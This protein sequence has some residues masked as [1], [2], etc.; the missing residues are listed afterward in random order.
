MESLHCSSVIYTLYTNC[1]A[2]VPRRDV[3]GYVHPPT[4]TKI[5]S[6]YVYVNDLERSNEMLSGT[7]PPQNVKVLTTF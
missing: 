3:Q 2:A 4:L 1:N 5:M 6:T 7:K